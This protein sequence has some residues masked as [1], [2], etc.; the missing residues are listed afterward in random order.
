MNRTF[1]IGDIHGAFKALQQVIERAAVKQD[2]RLIFLGDF[3]DGWS[4]SF[5]VIEYVAGLEKKM[6]CIFI[7]GN[8]DLWCQEWLETNFPD[9]NWLAHGGKATIKS[10]QDHSQSDKQDHLNFFGRMQNYYVDKEN[11]LFIHAGFSSP[12]GPTENDGESD[13]CWDR[14]LWEMALRIH[15]RIK[16]NLMLYPKKLEL[17]KEIFIGHTPTLYF[18]SFEPMNAVNVWNIDTGAAFT[19]RLTIMDVHTKQYWQSDVVRTLYPN[20]TGRNRS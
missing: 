3:V 6:D 17:F 5:E 7:K 18:D 11:R 8:H 13:Y 19:G 10:Y 12:H 15:E 4:E 1:V 14:T 16:S 9:Q 20:E 2:D